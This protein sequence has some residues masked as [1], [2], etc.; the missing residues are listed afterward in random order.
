MLYVSHLQS[1]Y[2]TEQFIRLNSEQFIRLKSLSDWTVYQSEQFNSLSDWTV[3]Q[4]E[5]PVSVRVYPMVEFE[6]HT[7]GLEDS[8]WTG[9]VLLVP[10]LWTWM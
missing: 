3:Y 1:V 9:G 8:E 10:D 7:S 5:Q 6:N 2:Q 4:N